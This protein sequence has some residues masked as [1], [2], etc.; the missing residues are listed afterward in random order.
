MK[1]TPILMIILISIFGCK[2]NKS[3]K[4]KAAEKLAT[5]DNLIVTDQMM[6]KMKIDELYKRR[7][8]LDKDSTM[9][10]VM[11]NLALKADSVDYFKYKYT[12]KQDSL[13]RDSAYWNYVHE[14]TKAGEK[15]QD[16]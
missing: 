10:P 7:Y 2:Y 9:T 3:D 1:K 15:G 8:V 16:D 13:K 11:K 5:Y 6:L 14:M 4:T 12:L